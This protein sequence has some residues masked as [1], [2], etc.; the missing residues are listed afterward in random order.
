MGKATTAITIPRFELDS[1]GAGVVRGAGSTGAAEVVWTD[2]ELVVGLM[3]FTVSP[4]TNVGALLGLGTGGL[5]PSVTT[6]T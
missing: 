1:E 6:I 3:D 2:R 5:A 4:A